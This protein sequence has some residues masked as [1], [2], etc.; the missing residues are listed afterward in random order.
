MAFILSLFLIF[1]GFTALVLLHFL[2]THTTV[3]RH[4]RRHRQRQQSQTHQYFRNSIDPNSSYSLQDLHNLLPHLNYSVSSLKTRDCAICLE[5]FKEGEVCRKLP[6]CT[7][8][9]HRN[10]VDNWLVKVPTCPIC[11]TRVQLDS[12]AWGSKK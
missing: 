10:C 2:F 3:H 6:D 12:G 9:F 1:L 11:R 7:H 4:S 5:G 8:L